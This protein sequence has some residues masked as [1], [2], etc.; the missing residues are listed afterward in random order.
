MNDT[1][2]SILATAG[3]IFFII[4]IICAWVAFFTSISNDTNTYELK[5]RIKKLEKRGK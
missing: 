2:I 4:T 3:G 1:I 5:K